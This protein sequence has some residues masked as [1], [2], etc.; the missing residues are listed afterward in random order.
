[1]KIDH[2]LCTM[3]MFDNLSDIAYISERCTLKPYLPPKKY[4][5]T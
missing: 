3:I 1:M 4:F 5:H 2:A